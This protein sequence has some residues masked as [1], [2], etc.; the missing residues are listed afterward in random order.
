[1]T[2]VKE[3]R[4]VQMDAHAMSATMRSIYGLETLSTALSEMS[5]E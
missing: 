1:M 3:G 5:F 2:A 4:I